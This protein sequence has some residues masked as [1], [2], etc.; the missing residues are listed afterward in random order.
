MKFYSTI[1]LLLI[2][3]ALYAQENTYHTSSAW[4]SA[5]GD[6]HL[7]DNFYGKTEFHV[8]RTGFTDHWQQLLIRPSLHYKLNS[9]VDFALGYT[10]IKNYSYASYSAPIDKNEN[11]IWQQVM[12]SH[13]SGK[14]KFKHRFRYEERFIDKMVEKDGK[15][16]VDGTTFASRFRYR[17]TTSF[18]LVNIGEKHELSAQIFDEIWLNLNDDMV[19]PERLNQ[20]W[21]YA[22][23]AFQISEKA[24]LGIGYLNDHL[25]LSGD[26]FETNNI[27]Q[28][29]LSYHF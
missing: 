20:N 8:R 9:T 11:N 4:F 29:T 7:N 10:F 27:L 1:L 12:L 6:V 13:Q 5:I 2:G 28:T 25:A 18:P 14:V 17:F 24:S 22:G 21:F 16:S 15:L 3:S 23:L 26:N 19:L